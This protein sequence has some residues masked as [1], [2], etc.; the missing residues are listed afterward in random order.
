MYSKENHVNY[1]IIIRIIPDIVYNNIIDISN[2]KYSLLNDY[3]YM[4]NSHG[5][6]IPVT[7]NMM[8]H[9]FYGNINIMEEI[10]NTYDNIKNIYY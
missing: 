1:D 7:K 8:G 5:N 9:F 4:P 3:L 10:M 6:Y 2:I